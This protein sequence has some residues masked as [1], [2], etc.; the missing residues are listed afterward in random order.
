[1]LRAVA[2]RDK[3]CCGC[4]RMQPLGM[5][6][7]LQTVLRR[8]YQQHKVLMVISTVMRQRPMIRTRRCINCVGESFAVKNLQILKLTTPPRVNSNAS[9]SKRWLAILI[10]W[11]STGAV[12]WVRMNVKL[13]LSRALQCIMEHLESPRQL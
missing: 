2:K 6:L 11:L 3:G 5:L 13:Q 1:M 4:R 7:C 9:T 10:A 12:S 8:E